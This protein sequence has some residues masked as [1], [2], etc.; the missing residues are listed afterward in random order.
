MIICSVNFG[1]AFVPKVGENLGGLKF[2]FLIRPT[3]PK[4]RNDLQQINE[5]LKILETKTNNSDKK[6]YVMTASEVFSDDTLKY[7]CDYFDSLQ[8][9]ELK[10][11]IL[12]THQMDSRDGFP[13]DMLNAHYL[14]VTIPTD[15][16][17][18]PNDQ[19]VLGFLSEQIYEQKNIGK[20]FQKLN[21]SFRL[22]DGRDVYLYE[23]TRKFTETELREISEM[24]V[25]FYPNKRENF[26]ITDEMIKEL[27]K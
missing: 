3:H 23:K 26:E 4:V 5:L 18:F 25:G 9:S 19:R 27:A 14:I 10:K 24:F 15:Y 20:A 21:Y 1:V 22:D 17:Y 2:A 13:F 8:F 6:I 12:F 11:R 16:I 7:G